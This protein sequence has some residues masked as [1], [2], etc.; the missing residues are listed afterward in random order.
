[1][2]KLVNHFFTNSVKSL[3]IAENN[4]LLNRSNHLNNPVDIALKKFENHPSIIDIKENVTPEANFSFSI[5]AISDIQTEIRK[6]DT[7]KAGTFSNISA[8]QLK[9]QIYQPNN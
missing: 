9:H 6:L 3:N 7:N 1:M 8:K 4:A 2:L 5:V